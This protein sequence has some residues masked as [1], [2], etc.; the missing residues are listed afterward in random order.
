LVV[1]ISTDLVSDKGTGGRPDNRP[2]GLVV[3]GSDVSQN[4]ASEP[5]KRCTQ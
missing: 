2:Q 4:A 1:E 3:I 5:A